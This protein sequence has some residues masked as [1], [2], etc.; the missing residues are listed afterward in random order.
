MLCHAG[1]WK[2]VLTEIA[3][4]VKDGRPTLVGTTS[5][6]RSEALAR[7]LVE[8]GIDYQV[9]DSSRE[10]KDPINLPE[11]RS[12]RPLGVIARALLPEGGL[13]H[14][15]SLERPVVLCANKCGVSGQL[16]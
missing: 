9:R 1:K 4:M 13:A 10:C 7:L 8:E 6:E 5:V 12:R 2:A 16:K 14:F 11:V 15:M 3:R